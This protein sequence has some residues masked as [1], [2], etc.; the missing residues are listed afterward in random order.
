MNDLHELEAL[1]KERLDE[2]KPVPPRD[3]QMASG[4][5]ARFLGEAVSAQALP[6]QNGWTSIFRKERYAM[7][8]VLSILVVIGLLFGGGATAVGAAQDDLPN[9]PLYA[10]KT[11]TEELSLKFQNNDEA[12]VNRLMELAQIRV[13]EMVQLSEGGEPIP[14][15]VRLRLEQHIQQAFQFCANMDDPALERALLRMRDRLRDQ[16]RDMDRLQL[17]TQNQL[18][19]QTRA[20]IQERLRLVEDGLLNHEMFRER[21][22]NGFH[23]G[24]DDEPIPPVIDGNSQQ[25]GQPTQAPGGLNLDPGGPNTDSGGQNAN[26]GGPNTDPGGPN[27]DPGGPNTDPGGKT[28]GSGSGGAGSG[29][30]SLNDK[31]SSGNGKP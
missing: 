12:K 23:Y 10:L 1:V 7:N 25:N 13:Q 19:T 16:D 14:D 6:R 4:R 21:V 30:G 8:V 18:I 3:Q 20:M 2:I 29:D 31:D 26:P 17:H 11:L 24:Q 5:R 22:Q 15:Q 9:E 28:N 27:T